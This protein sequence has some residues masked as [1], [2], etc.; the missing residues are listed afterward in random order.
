MFRLFALPRTAV[1][2]KD[3]KSLTNI[4]SRGETALQNLFPILEVFFL[5]LISKFLPL[6]LQI[7]KFRH[8]YGNIAVLVS[9]QTQQFVGRPWSV[10]ACC[11]APKKQQW[12]GGDTRFGAPL[13]RFPNDF[14]FCIGSSR[15]SAGSPSAYLA[16]CPRT[17]RVSPHRPTSLTHEPHV[18]LF[19]R[20][21]KVKEVTALDKYALEDCRHLA[22]C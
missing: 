20:L 1:S 19:C 7:L 5:L 2:G 17:G 15:V 21:E 6:P 9:T 14:T 12:K 8:S 18:C 16:A 11:G 13:H 4:L 3:R 10:K 22:L